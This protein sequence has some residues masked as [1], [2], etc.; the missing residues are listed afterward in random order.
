MAQDDQ[1][2]YSPLSGD[3]AQIGS[4]VLMCAHGT[5]QLRAQGFAGFQTAPWKS[6]RPSA[7]CLFPYLMLIGISARKAPEIAT[8]INLPDYL[9]S[10]VCRPVGSESQ[11][12][13]KITGLAAIPQQHGVYRQV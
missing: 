8:E 7:F 3:G 6:S 12:L 5:A 13:R 11:S 4:A 1:C 9:E 2:G 10:S